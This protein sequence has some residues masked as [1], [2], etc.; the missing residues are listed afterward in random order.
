MMDAERKTHLLLLLLQRDAEVLHA[1][2]DAIAN[3]AVRFQRRVQ[4]LQAS[5][6]VENEH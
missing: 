2:H 4:V 3:H 5:E 1:E 6:L